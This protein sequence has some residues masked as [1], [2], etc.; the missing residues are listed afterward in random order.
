MASPSRINWRSCNSLGRQG[1]LRSRAFFGQ[2]S[3]GQEFQFGFQPDPGILKQGFQGN[4][5][6]LFGL[7]KKRHPGPQQLSHLDPIRQ[8]EQILDGRIA[9]ELESPSLDAPL[10][11]PEVR[12]KE[13]QQLMTEIFGKRCGIVGQGL[14][15][16]PDGCG[17]LPPL[18]I[19]DR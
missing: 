9:E 10:R 15:K 12:L 19:P 14:E 3:L 17:Q 18:T 6:D 8:V 16:S 1:R 13:P 4:V 11:L 7:G 5:E 2:E